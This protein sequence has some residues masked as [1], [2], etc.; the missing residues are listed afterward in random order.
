MYE[1]CFRSGIVAKKVY[2]YR[3]L[4][5]KSIY[6]EIKR[7]SE[8]K[9][10]ESKELFIYVSNIS[11]NYCTEKSKSLNHKIVLIPNDPQKT[12]VEILDLQE[13]YLYARIGKEDDINFLM[14]RNNDT[15]MSSDISVEDGNHAEKFTY[16]YIDFS[17]KFVTF[18]F[19][20]GAPRAKRIGDFLNIAKGNDHITNI[21]P[22][23]NEDTLGTLKKKDKVNKLTYYLS[24]PSDEFLSAKYCNVNDKLF[25]R[26]KNVKC[27]N[28][29]FSLVSERNKNVT[30]ENKSKSEQKNALIDFYNEVEKTNKKYLKAAKM[31]GTDSNSNSSDEYDLF[32]ELITSKIE[33]PKINIEKDFI[34]AVR[35]S[36]LSAYTK[37]KDQLLL[38]SK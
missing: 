3:V 32:E 21:I 31:K 38:A 18:L 15:G 17:T 33:M 12:A 9:E 16:F 10:L 29:T 2:F 20:Q 13:N 35:L 4:V 27:V 22:I 6:N 5:E 14:Q 26:L 1:I 34:E 8:I 23:A 37:K 36:L 25:K 30:F 7:K 24:V 11:K 19:I 28:M